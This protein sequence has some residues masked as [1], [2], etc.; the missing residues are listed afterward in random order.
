MGSIF[1]V[2]IA[3]ADSLTNFLGQESEAIYSVCHAL[4]RL[5]YYSIFNRVSLGIGKGRAS[6]RKRAARMGSIP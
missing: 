1:A 6:R 3:F 5:F 2:T 4:R